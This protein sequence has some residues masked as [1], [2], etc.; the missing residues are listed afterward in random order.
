MVE[1]I[2]HVESSGNLQVGLGKPMF[3]TLTVNADLWPNTIQY[4]VTAVM[5]WSP[6]YHVGPG[7]QPEISIQ[8][9]PSG[10][11][12]SILTISMHQV[13]ILALLFSVPF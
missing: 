10:P 11:K 2:W 12:P 8:L 9:S 5:K 6:L 4:S 3:E 7:Q 1:H 13:L